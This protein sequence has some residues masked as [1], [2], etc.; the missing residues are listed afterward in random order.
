MATRRVIRSTRWGT[1]KDQTGA[2]IAIGEKVTAVQAMWKES[3]AFRTL[4]RRW[5]AT[6]CLPT[7][8]ALNSDA[9]P[10][11]SCFAGSYC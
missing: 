3:T 8:S 6:G 4:F 9:V 10:S 5:P 11:R 1:L 7:G 2:P